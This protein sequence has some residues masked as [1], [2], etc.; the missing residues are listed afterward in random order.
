MANEWGRSGNISGG[1]CTL[2]EAVYATL[3]VKSVVVLVLRGKG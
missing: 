3:D 2:C 1:C